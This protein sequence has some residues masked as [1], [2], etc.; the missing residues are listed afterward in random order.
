[1]TIHTLP[2]VNWTVALADIIETA[3]AGDMII[4]S[5]ADIKELAERA[6][7]RMSKKDLRF[8]VQNANDKPAGTWQC[9]ACGEVWDGSLLHRDPASIGATVW[10]CS[11][12]LCGGRCVPVLATEEDSA[13][14]A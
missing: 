11:N 1:M 10:T 7:H 2:V 8:V 9:M 14:G 3:V 4:V 5:S 12:W 6:T 13:Y